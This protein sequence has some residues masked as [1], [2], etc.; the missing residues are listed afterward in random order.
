MFKSHSLITQDFKRY[1]LQEKILFGIRTKS[2][3][4][5]QKQQSENNFILC[6]KLSKS[7]TF[8]HLQFIE[9]KQRVIFKVMLHSKVKSEFLM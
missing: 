4:L 5:L 1:K 6:S 3:N 2:N 9:I 8:A 7:F